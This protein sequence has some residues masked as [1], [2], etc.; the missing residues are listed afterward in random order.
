MRLCYGKDIFLGIGYFALVFP[1]FFVGG[2]VFHTLLYS[3]SS[4][5]AWAYLAQPRAMPLWA[6]V[7]ILSLG[8]ITWSPTEEATYPAHA[9]ARVRA[10]SGR[11]WV[12]FAVVGF[13]WAFQHRVLSFP[14]G[15]AVHPVSYPGVRTWRLC[16]DGDL[17][18]Y[19]AGL[20]S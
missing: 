4:R 3:T 2:I 20:L 15:L 16:H 17:L 14:I 6:V 8:W 13:V 10:L 9:L 5:D 7:Y 1:L 11:T 19:A 18:A 12:A